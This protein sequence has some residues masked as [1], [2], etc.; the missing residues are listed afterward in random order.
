MENTGKIGLIIEVISEGERKTY[1]SAS[2]EN[3]AQ[4]YFDVRS[5]MQKISSNDYSSFVDFVCYHDNVALY[6]V[7]RSIS[8][9]PGDAICGMITIPSDVEISGNELDDIINQTKKELAKSSQDSKFLDEL[10][11]K[12]YL[13][14]LMGKYRL[15]RLN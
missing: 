9:R 15:I 12:L 13:M 8:G 1:I 7:C 4:I 3:W 14:F 11:D 6:C 10:F 5:Y 2:A